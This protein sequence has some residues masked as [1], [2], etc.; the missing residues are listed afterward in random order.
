M[1]MKSDLDLLIEY[2]EGEKL[3]L[4][5]SVKN[6]LLENDY[7]YAHYQQEGLWRLNNQLDILKGFKDPLYNQKRDL[8]VSIEWSSRFKNDDYFSIYKDIIAERT[9]ELEKLN[10]QKVHFYFNDS[11]VIDDAL[12]DLYEHRIKKFRLG[13]SKSSD[14]YLYFELDIHNLL[15]ISIKSGSVLGMYGYDL[16][17]YDENDDESQLFMLKKMGFKWSNDTTGW[18]VY[19]FD[20]NGFK[21]AIAIKIILARI[22]YEIFGLTQGLEHPEATVEY[23]A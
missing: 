21:D 16:D 2:Y 3:I 14:L 1:L 17:D 10:K 6:Y 5:S 20:M 22:A 7:L 4:E 8:M 12:F 23:L 15:G 18:I 13:L 11:Q 19:H 9:V